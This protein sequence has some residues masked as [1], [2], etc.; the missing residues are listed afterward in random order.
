MSLVINTITG[1]KKC[2]NDTFIL[3][4][5]RW[6]EKRTVPSF[7]TIVLAVGRFRDDIGEGTY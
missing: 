3:L 2:T 6:M 1:P 4:L 7:M 5:L